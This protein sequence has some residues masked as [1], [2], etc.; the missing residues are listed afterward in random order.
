MC[1]FPSHKTIQTYISYV[2]EVSQPFL[3]KNQ[4]S[5]H[6]NTKRNPLILRLPLKVELP[7][8]MYFVF[9]AIFLQCVRKYFIDDKVDEIV[10]GRPS[11]TS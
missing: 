8:F 4:G 5:I 9:L 6:R 1:F 2:T 3:V 11:K 10:D 7:N